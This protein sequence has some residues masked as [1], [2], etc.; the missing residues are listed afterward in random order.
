MLELLLKF[1]K[2]RTIIIEAVLCDLFCGFC[3]SIFHVY[4]TNFQE[5]KIVNFNTL[6]LILNLK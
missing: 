5:I 4:G 1:I 3:A 2:F 6:L